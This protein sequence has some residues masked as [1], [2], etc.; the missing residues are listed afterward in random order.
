MKRIPPAWKMTMELEDAVLLPTMA[1]IALANVAAAAAREV[2]HNGD[3]RRAQAWVN[4]LA[5]SAQA[6]QEDFEHV[7]AALAQARQEAAMLRGA[8][9]EAD[10]ENLALTM[11]IRALKRAQ[12]N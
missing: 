3:L 11:D 2:R 10:Q 9:E 12:V 8:L 6:A 7:V 4:H 1:G 5:A